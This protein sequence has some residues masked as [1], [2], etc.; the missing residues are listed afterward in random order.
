MIFI[1]MF[2]WYSQQGGGG[3]VVEQGRFDEGAGAGAP[4]LGAQAAM[5][6]VGAESQGAWLAFLK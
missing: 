3:E 2:A 1:D 5:V 4:S 6:V